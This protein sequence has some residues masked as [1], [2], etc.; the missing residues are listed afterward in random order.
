MKHV[1]QSW[2][3]IKPHRE[4]RQRLL[5]ERAERFSHLRTLKLLNLWLRCAKSKK[6]KA[7]QLDLVALFRERK[8][9]HELFLRWS[10]AILQHS[11]IKRRALHRLTKGG[12]VGEHTEGK[13]LEDEDQRLQLAL[14]RVETGFKKHV[15]PWVNRVRYLKGQMLI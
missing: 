5:E 11:K 15:R 8:L 2:R 12:G 6:L 13:L 1:F 3:S 14:K 10:T 9:L 4:S 7:S